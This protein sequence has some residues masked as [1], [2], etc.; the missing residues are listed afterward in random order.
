M[1]ESYSYLVLKISDEEKETLELAK[2]LKPFG[3]DIELN[4][5]QLNYDS[6]QEYYTLKISYNSDKLKK[7]Q[8]RNAGVKLQYNRKAYEL[9]IADI[10]K[11]LETET[12]QAIADE[13]GMSRMTLYR[14]LKK[15]N[16]TNINK[17]L[18]IMMV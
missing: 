3:I 5:S 13:L 2:A 18:S 8:T 15:A 11:R 9:S 10:E 1:K 6:S 7:K 4:K 17:S 16:E 12:C 14:K